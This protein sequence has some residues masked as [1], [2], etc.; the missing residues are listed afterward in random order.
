MAT[1]EEW[2]LVSRIAVGN[3]DGCIGCTLHEYLRRRGANDDDV[4]AVEASLIHGGT[5]SAMDTEQIIA[6][7]LYVLDLA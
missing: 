2:P 6:H 4:R 1:W 3:R 7:F 5:L